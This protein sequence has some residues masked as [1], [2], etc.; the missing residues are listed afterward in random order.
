M[1]GKKIIDLA[2]YR[3]GKKQSVRAPDPSNKGDLPFEEK[4]QDFIHR[5][6]GETGSKNE[7][8]AIFEEEQ[9][10]KNREDEGKE[11]KEE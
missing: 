5:P 8:I 2:Q 4:L 9:L 7:L 11:D 10:R 3:Q 1:S 6:L